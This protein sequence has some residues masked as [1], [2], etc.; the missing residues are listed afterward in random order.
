MVM[1]NDFNNKPPS[2]HQD[3]ATLKK[4]IPVYILML[5][6]IFLLAVSFYMFADMEPDS[7]AERPNTPVPATTAPTSTG[8]NTGGEST[9][10]TATDTEATATATDTAQAN[11]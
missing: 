10:A 2:N 3:E 1:G 5:V 4:R 7:P 6:G 11:Q 9:E 8:T